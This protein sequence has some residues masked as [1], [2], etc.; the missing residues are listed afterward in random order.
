MQFLHYRRLVPGSVREQSPP[1]R[2]RLSVERLLVRLPPPAPAT[3]VRHTAPLAVEVPGWLDPVQ[4]RRVPT[5]LLAM[6]LVGDSRASPISAAT[7][8]LRE[9][10][11]PPMLILP[12]RVEK[13]VLDVRIKDTNLLRQIANI[14]M[15]GSLY[16]GNSRY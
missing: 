6:L 4:V 1:Q 12:I 16:E 13:F 5:A 8:R 15:K 11:Q 3:P 9:R 2:S 10:V 7:I 14:L